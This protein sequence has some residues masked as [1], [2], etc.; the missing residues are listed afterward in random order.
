MSTYLGVG[1][2][3]LTINVTS[4]AVTYPFS[5]GKLL[6]TRFN[7]RHKEKCHVF[8][9]NRTIFKLIQDIIRK[10]APPPCG[11]GFQSTRTIFALIQDIFETHVLNKFH[12]DWAKNVT[13]RVL[14][15]KQGMP[16]E[17]IFYNNIIRTIVLTKFHEDWTINETS[18]V[19]TRKTV[20]HPGGYFHEDWTINVAF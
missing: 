19:F 1:L 8:Q 11:H 17:A 15:R 6:T 2:L 5:H 20:P 3:K 16:L 4:R 18:R 10:T 13:S 14:T 7:Y 9:W 12:V